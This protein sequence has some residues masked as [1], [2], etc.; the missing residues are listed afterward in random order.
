MQKMAKVRNCVTYIFQNP[1]QR[2][3]Q[4]Q[5]LKLQP[6]SWGL[7]KTDRLYEAVIPTKKMAGKVK[8]KLVRSG[9]LFSNKC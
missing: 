6:A 8:I 9:S 1:L 4:I 5:L 3:A 7:E 2:T